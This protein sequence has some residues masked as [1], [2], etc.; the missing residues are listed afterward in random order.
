MFSLTK[1]TCKKSVNSNFYLLLKP[2][3]DNKGLPTQLG[4]KTECA[5]L[6]FVLELG[7]TYQHIRDAHPEEEFV[8]VFTFNS[9]RKSMSTV[10][11]RRDGGFRMYT[12]GA[13][14][15]VLSKC[16]KIIQASEGAN[17]LNIAG[18]TEDDMN[19]VMKTVIDPMASNGL[20]T[21]CVAYKDFPED[22]GK[23]FVDFM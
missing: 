23:L 6:G 7:G 8:K 17:V 5:L 1:S 21:I 19:N 22:L 15:M 12:K 2:S 18:F 14:E 3:E 10:I 16:D 11:K 4:N 20:R 9:K 13:S